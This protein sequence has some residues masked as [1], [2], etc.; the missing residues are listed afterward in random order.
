MFG[1]VPRTFE[2]ISNVV[3]A[4]DDNTEGTA[5]PPQ[6]LNAM[7][8]VPKAPGSRV[9]QALRKGTRLRPLHSPHGTNGYHYYLQGEQC[10]WQVSNSTIV[11]YD[12]YFLEDMP[13]HADIL[14]GVLERLGFTLSSPMA[15]ICQVWTLERTMSQTH[16]NASAQAGF[17]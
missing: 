17:F 3:I 12:F 15:E 11:K 2:T 10:V 14:N 13:S 4:R 5:S 7:E 8:F 9:Q 1:F 16:S 6:Y